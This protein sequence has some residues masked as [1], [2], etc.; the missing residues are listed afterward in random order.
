M[1]E[2]ERDP[3]ATSDE[4]TTGERC[5]VCGEP[6]LDSP[7]GVTC[8]NGHGGADPRASGDPPDGVDNESDGVNEILSTKGEDFTKSRLA[9]IIGIS[10]LTMDRYIR[11]GMPIKSRG[12]KR[13]GWVINSADSIQWIRKRDVQ[14]ANPTKGSGGID[15]AKLRREEANARKAELDVEHREKNSISTVDAAALVEEQLA[16]ARSL[17]LSMQGRLA[18]AVVG[19]EDQGE[20]ES[21]VRREVHAVMA[22]ISGSVD[23]FEGLKNDD[24]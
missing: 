14:N 16:I 12:F 8:A 23:D 19:I 15:Q 4:L 10:P 20:I 17:L 5:S 21:I 11:E 7:G 22:E 13:M 2:V 6:Q 3:F 9:N 18:A 1:G 24:A